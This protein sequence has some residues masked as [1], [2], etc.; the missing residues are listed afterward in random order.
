MVKVREDMTGWIMSEHG[1]PDSRLTIISQAED[2]IRPNGTPEARWLCECNCS[3]HTR[4]VINGRDIRSGKTKSC[5]CIQKEKVAICCSERN[6][7]TNL[8]VLNL[9]DEYGS[10]GY[11]ICNNTGAKFYFDMEDYDKIK[12]YCW[13]E[14]ILTNGYHRIEAREKETNKS[15]RITE[16]IG[17]KKY[18]HIDRN[19][20]NN[21]KYNLRPYKQSQNNMNRS[22]NKN[23][24]SGIIGLSWN[25]TKKKW[26]A[27]IG[28][29]YKA[30]SL[31]H[32]DNK[33]DAIIARLKAEK[34]YYCE[35][36]P[37]RHLFEQYKI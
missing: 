19:P 30:I 35:F 5:G 33:Q 29:N 20:L 6:K 10:Y 31:G 24:K 1:I 23:N 4:L 17:C 22:L 13:S 2:Y 14:H 18:D 12:E 8:F 27:S 37:Q 11:G 25:E 3:N 7:K 9:I 26:I 15:I 21:R 36:A 28:V 34:E 32:Y 16:L